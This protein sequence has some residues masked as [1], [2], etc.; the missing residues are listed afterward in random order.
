MEEYVKDQGGLH[1][2]GKFA[3]SP[4]ALAGEYIPSPQDLAGTSTLIYMR[5]M[6]DQ[7]L[8][9]HIASCRDSL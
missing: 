2:A 6:E 3:P 5:S 9:I 4:Q 7:L 1:M 8:M